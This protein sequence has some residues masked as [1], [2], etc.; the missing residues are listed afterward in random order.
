MADTGWGR[1]AWWEDTDL[2]RSGCGEIESSPPTHD[3]FKANLGSLRPCLKT[4]NQTS[5]PQP[6]KP[7]RGSKSEAGPVPSHQTHRERHTLPNCVMGCGHTVLREMQYPAHTQRTD[8]Q[9]HGSVTRHLLSGPGDLGPSHNGC[10]CRT[11]RLFF[12][13]PILTVEPGTQ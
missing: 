1:V 2:E 5:C 7:L 6:G 9:G 3:E 8:I 11:P 12:Y 13:H 10:L 4:N